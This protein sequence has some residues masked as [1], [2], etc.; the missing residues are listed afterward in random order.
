M[1]DLIHFIDDFLKY[2]TFRLPWIH[3]YLVQYTSRTCIQYLSSLRN[4][5]IRIW[6]MITVL[7]CW[8]TPRSFIPHHWRRKIGKEGE[9]RFFYRI[10]CYQL[11]R[12][13]FIYERGQFSSISLNSVLFQP[14]V[15]YFS[16][17]IKPSWMH[18]SSLR[19]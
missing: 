8:Q 17:L 15:G 11:F 19:I 13:I 18:S 10:I 9:D 7:T 2:G 6:I 1:S 4:Y 3:Y 5:F 16:P 12:V 14:Q